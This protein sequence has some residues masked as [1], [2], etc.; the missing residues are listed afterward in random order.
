MPLSTPANECSPAS[1]STAR[2]L[3]QA[4]GLTHVLENGVTIR[5]FRASSGLDQRKRDI[6]LSALLAGSQQ[7]LRRC[8]EARP[9]HNST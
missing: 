1:L 5:P 4:V 2:A 7:H 9:S 3:A 6:Q 8:W